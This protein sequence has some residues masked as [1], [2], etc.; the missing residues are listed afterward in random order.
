MTS[1]LDPGAGGRAL[2]RS[3]TFIGGFALAGRLTERL[4]AFGQTALI[5]SAFGAGVA[6][7]VYFATIIVPL[8]IGTLVGESAAAVVLPTLV[9]HGEGDDVRRRASAGFWLTLAVAVGALAVYL[10][11]L[12]PL[13]LFR[14]Q[15]GFAELGPW[16]AFAPIGVLLASSG[17]LG[18]ILLWRE[19]YVWPPFRTAAAGGAAFV[20]TAIVLTLT[21]DVV[22]V[23][24]AV[25]AGY[26]ASTIVGL[27]EVR[28]VLG[29]HWLGLPERKPLRDIARLHR[30]FSAGIVSGLLGGQ[31]LVVAERLLAAGLGA[32]AVAAISYA[33]G[34]AFMPS[35]V[36]HAIA[37]ASYP[38]MVREH[39]EDRLGQ[40]RVRLLRGTRLTL[41]MASCIAV[42]LALFGPNLVAFLL[43]RGAFTLED[44]ETVGPLVS[45]FAV[46]LVA[47][48]A[49]I[50]L[51]RVFQST[52]YFAATVWTQ[53]SIIASYAVLAFALRAGW[54]ER[55][56]A[57]GFGLAQFV[58]VV[59]AVRLALRN[60]SVPV[61]RFLRDAV[62]PALAR[63][64]VF[65][66]VLGG[67]RLALAELPVPVDLV[68]LFYVV[69]STVVAGAVGAALLWTSGWAESLGAVTAIR[70]AARVRRDS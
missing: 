27:V 28:H 22:W 15:G 36:G 14:F 7:D 46:A 68:G 53:G 26:A 44:V 1:A 37:A 30:P 52:D 62:V 45:I 16:L 32:G 39:V 2:A 41:Y 34:L 13:V 8:L 12:V 63:V 65:A 31:V 19:R 42:F 43:Q 50:F 40:I 59:V 49:V 33:R 57:L 4:I 60:L 24:A 58:G 29:R 69:G 55:G 21:R 23:A 5:A 48:M 11:V 35:V 10:L 66:L 18:A 6:A 61:A 9:R 70:A 64:G 47:N 17:Y 20:G 54:D 51:T 38:A 56:L 25:T 67:Y 3:G